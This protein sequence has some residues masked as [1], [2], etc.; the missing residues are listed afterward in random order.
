MDNNKNKD[1]EFGQ[2]VNESNID[3]VEKKVIEK[4]NNTIS[5]LEDAIAKWDNAKTRPKDLEPKFTGYKKL[6]TALSEWEKKVLITKNR[7]RDYN[8]RINMLQEFVN[9]CYTKN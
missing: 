4:V 8:E 7:R 1:F 2:P 5:V 3:L 9:I 6:H